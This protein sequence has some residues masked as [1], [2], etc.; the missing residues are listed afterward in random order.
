MPPLLGVVIDFTLQQENDRFKKNG[1]K[2]AGVSSN[3]G[4]LL[5]FYLVHILMSNIH[6]PRSL[7]YFLFPSMRAFLSSPFLG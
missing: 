5:A 7:H 2:N 3:E 6:S 1:V 4:R